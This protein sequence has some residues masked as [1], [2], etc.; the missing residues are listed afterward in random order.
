MKRVVALLLAGGEG[1]RMAS[2]RPKQFVEI[3]GNSVLGITLAVFD[4]HPAVTDLCVVCAPS[5]TAYVREQVAHL[6]IQKPL[7]LA[8]SGQSSIL[9]LRNGLAA[10]GEAFQ[11]E[12]AQE[13]VVMVHDAVRPLVDEGV[14]N[15]NLATYAQRG[16]AISCIQSEEAYLQSKDGMQSTEVIKRDLLWRAQTPMTFS[17]AQLQ[18]LMQAAES[19]N[20]LQS[21]SLITLI[22]EVLP[23]EPLYVALGSR[24]NFKIT[25]PEDIK[26]L[27]ALINHYK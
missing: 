6:N 20:I 7:V 26:L 16:N 3:D 4:Q 27:R 8:P 13:V 11:G 18:H 10:I 2:D 15:R 22:H 25:Y 23:N 12:T 14:L 17:L 24:A 1:H 21:Q 5:W 9:S 19:Q